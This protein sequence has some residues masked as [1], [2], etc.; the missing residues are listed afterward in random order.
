MESNKNHI[1]LSKSVI[2]LLLL[3][4]LILTLSLIKNFHQQQAGSSTPT[5]T[6]PPTFQAKISQP[7]FC[8][9]GPNDNYGGAFIVPADINVEVLGM[10]LEG[11]WFMIQGVDINRCWIKANALTLYSNLDLERVLKFITAFT[12]KNTPCLVYPNTGSGVQTI[13]PE[14][15]RVVAYGKSDEDA[16]WVLIVPHDSTELCWMERTALSGFKNVYLPVVPIDKVLT[17]TPMPIPTSMPTNVLTLTPT[18][19]PT[20]TREPTSTKV[21]HDNGGTNTPVLLTPPTSVPPTS[22]PPTSVP[23]TPTLCWP[24]GHCH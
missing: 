4:G 17:P 22:V 18:D 20:L 13:I 23:P 11:D 7:G 3:V 10:T 15:W 12:L 6:F 14:N 2:A 19:A 16:D 1:D 9:N 8:H 5:A 21:P 24:P